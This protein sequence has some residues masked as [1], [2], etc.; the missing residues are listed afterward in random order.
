M[1]EVA[2]AAT[3]TPPFRYTAALAERDRAR[4]GRTSGSERGHLPRPEPDRAAG[5]PGPPPGRAPRSCT[6]WTCSR[7]RRARACTSGTRWATSA[8]TATPASSGWPGATCCTRWASTRSGCRPSSTRCRP[9]PTRGPP[10]RQHRALPGAAAPAGPGPR[11][12][13]LGGHHRHRVLPLD[14]VDL[15]AGLQLLVRPGRAQGPADRR[16]DRRVRGGHAARPRTAGPGP[17]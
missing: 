17:T 4:A 9:A 1:S 10:P 12:P 13:A 6:C 11:R 16:A 15:P 3:D 8:P 7:T 14:P 2:A 5:R